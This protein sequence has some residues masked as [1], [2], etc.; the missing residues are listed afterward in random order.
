MLLLKQLLLLK[1][2]PHPLNE[3][4][5]RKHHLIWAV[6]CELLILNLFLVA[7]SLYLD[8]PLVSTLLA[9][10]IVVVTGNLLLLKKNH[11]LIYS[12]HIINVLCFCMITASNIWLGGASTSTLD[13]FY[14]SPIIAAVTIGLEGLIIY[15]A[16]SVAMLLVFISGSF[17]PYHT[18]SSASI[19]VLS[20]INPVFIFLLISSILYSLLKENKHYESLLKEQNFLLFADKQKFHYLS[21]HDSLT[22][23]PNRSYFHSH[24]EEVIACAQTNHDA[25]T[26]YFMDL[27]HFKKINDRYGHEAGDLLLLQTSKRLQSCFREHDFIARLGGDEFTAVIKHHIN[28]NIS[29]ALSARIQ[30]EFK[31][32]FMIKGIPIKCNISTGKA[33]YPE[34]AQTIEALLKIADES[35][36]KNKKK[37]KMSG[38]SRAKPQPQL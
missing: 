23:L 18:L 14:I 6:S 29:D 38:L 10:S 16:L 7:V 26:L 22:N 17:T 36:Y 28:D 15:G 8:I 2:S 20:T 27:D 1:R 5:S 35:M 11:S 24:L 9:L 34:E 3:D 32:P 30:S 13:W 19:Q 4:H 12:G 37:G 31:E 21:H 33:R 25:V